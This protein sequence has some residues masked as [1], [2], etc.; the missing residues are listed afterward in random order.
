M[1][2]EITSSFDDFDFFDFS[3]VDPIEVKKSAVAN[4]LCALMAHKNL[5]RARL[6]ERLNWKAS[7]LT[8]VLSGQQNLTVKTITEV[9]TALEYDFKLCFYK[10]YEVIHVQPWEKSLRSIPRVI[11]E[12]T[13]SKQFM[14]WQLQTR[15]EVKKDFENNEFR[16]FYISTLNNSVAL[17]KIVKG[18]DVE[19][20]TLNK[21]NHQSDPLIT[22]P[23][24]KVTQNV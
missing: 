8:K 6:A 22:Y 18:I 2:K 4:E 12:K 13:S 24:K 3:D 15:D 10:S 17:E 23:W 7:R 20:K 5:S 19:S 9:A 1:T 11:E 21:L 16:A 14:I